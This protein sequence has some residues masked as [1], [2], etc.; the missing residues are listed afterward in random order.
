MT[1][2]NEQIIELE[3]QAYYIYNEFQATMAGQ[4]MSDVDALQSHFEEVAAELGEDSESLWDKCE[5]FHEQY[6][7]R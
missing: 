7:N 5:S 3:N 6:I 2:T 4:T 1:L